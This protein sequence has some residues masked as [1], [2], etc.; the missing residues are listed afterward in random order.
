M[1]R[2]HSWVYDGVAYL[3]GIA[4]WQKPV[5]FLART[6]RERTKEQELTNPFEGISPMI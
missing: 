3:G 6:P 1:V 5:H 2:S 4:L